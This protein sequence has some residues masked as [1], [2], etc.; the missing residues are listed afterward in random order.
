M[1]HFVSGS[2]SGDNFDENEPLEYVHIV[3]ANV[4]DLAKA[5]R[6]R[7][8]AL[9]YAFD[10]VEEMGG[11][12]PAERFV[13]YRDIYISADVAVIQSSDIDCHVVATVRKTHIRRQ[14]DFAPINT[15]E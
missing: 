8:D 3:T 11:A 15:E 2:D 10:L 4:F 13:K 12:V 1:F 7:T 6:Y 14:R 5:F 9:Y